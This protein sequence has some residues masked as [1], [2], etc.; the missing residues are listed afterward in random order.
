M[1]RGILHFF[2]VW[3]PHVVSPLV[4]LNGDRALR[5]S[6]TLISTFS[7][8]PDV[9]TTVAFKHTGITITGVFK[10]HW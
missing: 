5:G 2:A 10:Q 8:H 3:S 7:Q 6:C 4:R 1:G 9:V